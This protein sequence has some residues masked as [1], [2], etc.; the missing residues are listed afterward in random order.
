MKY[1]KIYENVH[2]LRV[3]VVTNLKNYDVY[4]LLLNIKEKKTEK[5]R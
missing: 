3:Y 1:M 2:F 5:I 4:I